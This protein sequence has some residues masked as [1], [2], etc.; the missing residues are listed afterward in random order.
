MEFGAAA[1]PAAGID[2]ALPQWRA[3]RPCRA[4]SLFDDREDAD[5]LHARLRRR[6]RF[7]SRPPP[8]CGTDAR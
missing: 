4:A 2:I 6:A 1:A 3:R 7:S 5:P 8:L